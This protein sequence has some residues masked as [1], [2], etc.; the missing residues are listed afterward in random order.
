MFS[1][2]AWPIK[3]SLLLGAVSHVSGA[4]L[5]WE[6]CPNS[7]APNSTVN[8]S[9][10]FSAG[11]VPDLTGS[12]QSLQLNWS[13]WTTTVDCAVAQGLITAGEVHLT[14]LWDSKF[15]RTEPDVACRPFAF[16][17][18][19]SGAILDV[20]MIVDDF[21]PLPPLS[22]MHI[23]AHILWQSQ[24]GE[25]ELTC[26]LADATP[27]LKQR[28]SAAIDAV[29]WA[30]LAVVFLSAVLRTA[31]PDDYV[32]GVGPRLDPAARPLLPAL[33]DCLQYLQFIFLT[34]GLS[35]NY[36][37]FFQPA[38]ARL[39]WFSLF[40]DGDISR[41]PAYM[42]IR[43]GVYETNGTMTGQLGMDTLAQTIGAPA[44]MDIW[45]NMVIFFMIIVLISALVLQAY[46]VL[47]MRN[48]LGYLRAC[49]RS[50]SVALMYFLLPLV[51]F[52][53][54]EICQ[55]SSLILAYS[56]LVVVSL[57][58]ASVTIK[59]LTRRWVARRRDIKRLSAQSLAMA[60]PTLKNNTARPLLVIDERS[61]IL[62]LFTLTFV[63]GVA[64]G[65]LQV[66]GSAQLVILAV[67]DLIMLGCGIGLGIF[68]VASTLTLGAF[69]RIC[70]VALM[71][72]F[73]KGL[74][75]LDKT[76][77]II[78]YIILSL[79]ACVL[80]LGFL[81][82]ALYKLVMIFVTKHRLPGQVCDD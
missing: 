30:T 40:S 68:P 43:D 44:N 48:S 17:D 19:L 26:V 63:R 54:Y 78:G 72:T 25:A 41:R 80:I 74:A 23:E 46:Q 70:T 57:S 50:L 73:V 34:G 15:V 21:G 4:Y 35:V 71:F 39:H 3:L 29:S 11:I 37:G 12:H 51:S 64:I 38:I 13:F 65:G 18:G 76:R 8:D 59:W 28:V 7:G 9:P 69:V 42:G 10:T 77:A 58:V 2:P 62:L 20:P 47:L 6:T 56:L 5:H 75:V 22:T 66:A 49:H 81:C 33:G 79:H 61:I 32:P 60:G 82:P 16:P 55:S 36:P 24:V 27:A 14:T 1:R 31:F 52:S 45:L 67:C 53:V